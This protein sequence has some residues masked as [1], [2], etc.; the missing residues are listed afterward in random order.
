MAAD[1]TPEEMAAILAAIE[2]TWPRPV[3]MAPTA[4]PEPPKWR[5][6]GRW[7]ARPIPVRRDRP[8]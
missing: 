1:P 7:W 6:A 2:L 8:W 3:V 5:F 4:P